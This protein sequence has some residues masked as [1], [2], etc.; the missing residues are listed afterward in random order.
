MTAMGETMSKARQRLHREQL[1]LARLK[2]RQT[3]IQKRNERLKL[4]LGG[5]CYL[6]GWHELPEATLVNQ[7]TKVKHLLASNDTE[8]LTTHG[9]ILLNIIS[10]NN[11]HS[12][13][14]SVFDAEKRH[15]AMAIKMLMGGILLKHDLQ[16]YQKAT[17]L[18]AMYSTSKLTEH[19]QIIDRHQ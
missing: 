11:I 6:V 17:L 12:P 8:S 14:P 10:I 9:L 18:G 15:E 4:R 19:A 13:P 1:K 16:K 5:L 7:L 3:K 2:T